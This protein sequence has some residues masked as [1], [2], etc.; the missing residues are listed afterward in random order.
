MILICFKQ[1]S[2]RRLLD[3]M[4]SSSGRSRSPPDPGTS[5][6]SPDPSTSRPAPDPSTSRP[7]PDPSTSRPAP[8]PSTS[9]PA[10]DAGTS[11]RG[12]RIFMFKFFHYTCSISNFCL[13]LAGVDHGIC[14]TIPPGPLEDTVLIPDEPAGH[15]RSRRRATADGTHDPPI[16]FEFLPPLP[17][18]TQI[19]LPPQ[20]AQYERA[21]QRSAHAALTDYNARCHEYQARIAAAE[22]ERE[23]LFPGIIIEIFINLIL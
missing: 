21:R 8:D 2:M 17:P 5:Q 4:R 14:F 1:M 22:R 10:P 12:I 9:Q 3:R 18:H 19:T 15:T 16:E 13:F 20:A 11:T 23:A 7:S 6:P